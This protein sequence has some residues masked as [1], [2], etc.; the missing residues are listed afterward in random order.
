MKSLACAA[1]LCALICLCGTDANAQVGRRVGSSTTIAIP[2]EVPPAPPEVPGPDNPE[3]GA[4][5]KCECEMQA[6]VQGAGATPDAQSEQAEQ[7]YRGSEVDTKAVISDMPEPVYTEGARVQ[8]TSGRVA[9][10]VTLH[11][12]GRVTEVKVL[13]GLPDGLTKNAINAACQIK[14]TPARKDGRAVS[15][16]VTVE[17]NFDTDYMPPSRTRGSRFP[18]GMPLPMPRPPIRRFP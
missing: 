14:F 18:P 9:L 5:V 2:I 16:F 10:H 4:V 17:M 13:R 12:S 3:D 11:S 6:P 7:V 1:I 15:Q 8:G